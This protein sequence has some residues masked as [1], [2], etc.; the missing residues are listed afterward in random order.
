LITPLE[1]H[2]HQFS[3]SFRGY[4]EQEV[5]NFLIQIGE[6]YENLYRENNQL[7]EEIQRLEG[8]LTKYYKLE[9]TMNNTLIIA[10]QTAEEVKNNA[11]KEAE[12]MLKESKKRIADLLMLYQEVIKRINVL[13]VE[14]KSQIATQMDMLDKNDKKLEELADFFYSKDLKIIMENLEKETLKENE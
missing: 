4:N 2:N 5:K 9:E 8:E 13:N 1:I 11:H 6:N 12:L 14:L 3:K 7:K 10:Q